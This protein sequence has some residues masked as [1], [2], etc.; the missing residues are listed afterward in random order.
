MK[1]PHRNPARAALTFSIAVLLAGCS[2]KADPAALQSR[3]EEYFKAGKLDEA[4]IE[5][6]NLL[7]ADGRNAAGFRQLGV[8]WSDLGSPVQAIPFLAKAAQLAPG[9]FETRT[10]LARALLAVGDRAAARREALAAL[11]EKPSH[12]EALLALAETAGTRE[13]HEETAKFIE[14]AKEP[15]RAAVHL[16]RAVLLA[17]RLALPG[18]EAEI[19]KALELD[20]KSATA[21]LSLGTL[22]MLRGEREKAGE[23]FKSASQL[24]AP[25]TP[26]RLKYADFKLGE[27][28]FDE[29]RALFAEITKETRDYLPAWLGLAQVAIQ[30]KKFDEAAGYFENIFGRDPNNITGRL[31]QAQVAMAKGETKQ[32]IEGLSRL[33]DTFPSF[34]P[35]RFALAEAHLKDGD[36]K[37]AAAL[38]K[39]IVSANPDHAEAALQLA[40]LDLAAGNSAG[41]IETMKALLERRPGI[42]AAELMLGEG[43][44]AQGRYDEAAAVFE[45]QTKADPGN[46]G[47]HLMLGMIR[48]QKGDAAGS[49]AAFEKAAALAP[50]NLQA[51]QQLVEM[52]A[53]AGDFASAHRRADAELQRNPG[54]ASAHFLS[55]KIFASQKDWPKAEAAL[56]KAA[57]LEPASMRVHELLVSTYVESGRIAE[58]LARTEARLAAKP[59][60]S[61]A[62]LTAGL[63]YERT[64]SFQKACDAYEKL[65]ATNPDSVTALNN[66][67]VLYSDRMPKPDRALELARKARNL[68]GSDPSVA[69]TLGWALF[70][71]GEFEQA[72]ALFTE[73]VAK[74]P[75]SGEVQ[76][77]L[78]MAASMMGRTDAARAALEKAAKAPGDFAGR[79]DA[80]KRL[81]LLG[82]GSGSPSMLGSAELEALLKNQP[83]DVLT[84][85]RLG[86]AYEREGLAQKA[87]A[88]YEEALKLNPNLLSA[89]L[90][91]AQVNVGPLNNPAKAAEFARK[92]A[93]VAP[94]DPKAAELLGRASLK[95][96][97][98]ALAYS[99]LQP[100]AS[101]PDA[102]GPVLHDFAWAAYRMGKIAL[103]REMMQRL[104]MGTTDPTGAEIATTFLT[105]VDLE[106][107]PAD[108]AAAEPAVRKTLAADPEHVP[109]LMLRASLD[110]QR[111][112]AKA[113]ETAYTGILAKLP[114]FAPAQKRLA[115]LYLATPANR[116]KAYGLAARARGA[117]ADDAEAVRIFAEASYHRKD[118]AGTIQLYEE[119]ARKEPLD[120]PALFH[121]GMALAQAQDKPQASATLKKSL[122]AGLKEPQAAEAR[123]KLEE[124]AK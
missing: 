13:E 23:S 25:R 45:A 75:D 9:D 52:D 110:A 79:E 44:R 36:A 61:A 42:P 74:L 19:R 73:A 86:E 121:L 70:R 49:R 16:A 93:S 5:Y 35:V 66:L 28:A 58:A 81:A 46:T 21:H 2:K 48:R 95:T 97:N 56:L 39:E 119:A 87:A 7:K 78:G 96:G 89:L 63:L 88:S 38:L 55:G 27:G 8:I 64:G 6:M 22:Q 99:L 62:L 84:I 123:K 83:G 72:L 47:A 65:L 50:G 40:R 68:A 113:A 41:V 57:E 18:A 24:A 116:D 82:D 111:G 71:R 15:D 94:N 80:K 32:A 101:R 98:N 91:L 104:S 33:R 109:A 124:L 114:D 92:A 12:D 53:L 117:L 1:S 34:P 106:A 77:H 102:A 10:R 122:E 90:G 107:R 17:R 100:A 60:D 11:K 108:Q 76:Y 14:A 69:D 54:S 26:A 4:R 103:A 118:W 20:P 51:L 3:A 59:G 105:F 115:A 43:L 112:D 120:A 29:A 31:M 85:V 67:A 30:Q 37:Q